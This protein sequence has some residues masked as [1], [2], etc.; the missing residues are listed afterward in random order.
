M[1]VTV[2]YEEDEETEVRIRLF[3]FIYLAKTS[4][5]ETQD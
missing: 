5:K 3:I 4:R 1:P 2:I